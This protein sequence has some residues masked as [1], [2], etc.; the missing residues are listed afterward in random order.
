[1]VTTGDV[2]FGFQSPGDSPGFLLLQITQLWQRRQRAALEPLNLTHGQFVLLAGI[3]WLAKMGE[4]ISQVQLAQHVEAD[5][6]M[7]SEVLRSLERKGLVER[8]PHPHDSRAKALRLTPAAGPLVNQAVEI[9]EQV[10]REF[11]AVLG[12]NLPHMLD[13]M[14]RLLDQDE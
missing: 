5:V 13:L 6:M 12:D 14:Q 10:D 8:T 4:P 11:F 1:M 7:T 9:V 3:G 2:R